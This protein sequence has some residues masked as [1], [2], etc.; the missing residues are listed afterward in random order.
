MTRFSEKLKSLR[1]QYNLTQEQLAERLGVSR[2]AITKWE[3]DGGLPDIENLMEIAALFSFT[4]D[5]LLSDNKTLTKKSYTYESVT[6][7]DVSAKTHFDIHTGSANAIIIR[8]SDK[9]KLCVRLSSN[10]I[11][12]I[13]KDLKVKIDE[14][15]NKLDVELKRMGGTSEAEIKASLVIE[16]TLP[17]TFIEEIELECNAGKINLYGIESKIQLDCN[18]DTL[19][20]C[21]SLPTSLELNQIGKT[22]TLI[23]PQNADYR[24]KVIGKT[25]CVLR[26]LTD[27]IPTVQM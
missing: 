21:D 2:Q 17:K 24:I 19:I 11:S 16:I 12:N 1:K 23:I 5:D 20:T 4:L 27:P 7:Y 26:K 3:T 6:E 15:R 18:S 8:S 9:E 22:S 13:S 10:K 14:N 25:L